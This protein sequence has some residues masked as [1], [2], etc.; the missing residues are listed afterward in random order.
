MPAIHPDFFAVKLPGSLPNKVLDRAM[1]VVQC[2]H[3]DKPTLRSKVMSDGSPFPRALAISFAL[4]VAWNCL[5]IASAQSGRRAPKT[6]APATTPS[7]EST[8]ATVAA[9]EKPAPALHVVVGIDKFDSFS[10]VM[11]GTYNDVLR[12]C[13]QRLDEPQ[14]VTVERVDRALSR[15]EASSRAKREQNAYVV[16]LTL[17]EDQMSSNRTGTRNNVY[18]EYVLFAPTTA[19]VV[20]SGSV[21]PRKKGIIPSNDHDVIEASQ[22]VAGRIL[23]ALQM[24]MPTHPLSGL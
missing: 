10:S 7:P 4:I 3:A 23:A 22:T 24:H 2:G 16:W 18:I 15:G 5:A 9:L 21:Y 13:A 14:A 1:R 6:Q 20:S 12:S 17:R 19:K 11:I 8:P